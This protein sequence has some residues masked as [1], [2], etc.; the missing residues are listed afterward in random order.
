[1]LNIL[2]TGEHIVHDTSLMLNG[3]VLKESIT[4]GRTSTIGVNRINIR[5]NGKSEGAG[6][7]IVQVRNK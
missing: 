5:N 2:I 4:G 3:I 6:E 7:L 1:M